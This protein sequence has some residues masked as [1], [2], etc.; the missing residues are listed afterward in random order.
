MCFGGGGQAGSGNENCND[1]LDND[2]D[3]LNIVMIPTVL[4]ILRATNRFVMMVLIKMVM[5]Q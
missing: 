5:V 1:I 2:A 4:S 3:G